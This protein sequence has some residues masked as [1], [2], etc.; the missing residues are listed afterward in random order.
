[1]E[2]SIYA[3]LA[4]AQKEMKQ[5]VFD[6]ENPHFRSKYASLASVMDSVLPALINHGLFLS[7][8]ITAND[9]G[10]AIVTAVYDGE[11][12]ADLAFY[13]I[14]TT[15]MTAQQ[16]GSA[17][18]YA[19]RYSLASAFAR[20]ADT[21]DDGNTA[22][23]PVKRKAKQPA[24]EVITVDLRDYAKD[25]AKASS[26]LWKAIQDYAAANGGNAR[27][28]ANGLFTE[29]AA[30]DW[31]IEELEDKAAEFEGAINE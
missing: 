24:P 3:K 5:P 26:R 29:R 1:M 21:D 17:I 15:G 10:I 14:D 22:S 12:R 7:Q 25:R 18:T 23:E 30:E 4:A 8:G 2:T 16:I 20:V 9:A 27:E 6:C 28:I 19:K 11:T 31:S 13:P